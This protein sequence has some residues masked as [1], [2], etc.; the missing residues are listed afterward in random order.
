MPKG[1]Y[2][3]SAAAGSA[4]AACVMAL[5]SSHEVTGVADDLD[6]EVILELDPCG[7]L[8]VARNFATGEADKYAA[9]LQATWGAPV[10]FAG[11]WVMLLVQGQCVM[12]DSY[13]RRA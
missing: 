12:M 2:Q 6:P 4:D 9:H 8:V 13:P 11:V 1:W 5:P 10:Y 3:P 7:N